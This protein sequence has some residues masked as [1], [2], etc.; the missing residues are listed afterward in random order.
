M[1]IS[2]VLP[3]RNEEGLIEKTLEDIYK[4]LRKKKYTFEILVVING[5]TDS[6]EDK[7]KK[8]SRKISQIKILKSKLGYGFA[9]RKGLGEAKGDHVVVYNV[10]FY[11]FRLVDL[12]DHDMKGSDI[13]IGSKLAR[14]SKDGRPLPRRLVSLLFNYYLKLF[15]G[16]KGTDT[17]GIKLIKKKV[18]NSVLPLCKT[19]SGIFDTEFVLRVQ[20]KGFKIADIPV[21]VKEKRPSRFVGRLMQTPKDIYSLYKSFK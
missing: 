14:G 15:Y 11:D 8:L 5:S 2:I 10:D 4:Y 9:L 19:S 16:F 21:E 1:K 12:A 17:H 7:V 20:R 6:T 18:I 13:V 3:T